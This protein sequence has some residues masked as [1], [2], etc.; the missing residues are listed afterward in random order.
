MEHI[1]VSLEGYRSLER[2]LETLQK[3]LVEASKCKNKSAVEN[4]DVWHN[5]NDFEQM[6]IQERIIKKMR[7][8]YRRK[9]GRD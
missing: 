2:E 8:N 4:G 7:K 9:N 6:E 3:R 1:K 5:N